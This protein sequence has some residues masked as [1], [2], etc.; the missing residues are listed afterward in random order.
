MINLPPEKLKEIVT[1]AGAVDE[2][3]FDEVITEA[4]RK[5]QSPVE[6]L[7][8]RGLLSKE[9]FQFYGGQIQDKVKATK[10]RKKG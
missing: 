7:I 4:A 10:S 9:Y 3:T 2:A 5:R 6:I 8:S 1:R